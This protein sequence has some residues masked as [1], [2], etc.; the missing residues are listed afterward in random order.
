M[1]RS[2]LIG[3]E[4]RIRILKKNSRCAI[5]TLDPKTA[6]SSREIL[7]NITRNYGGFTGVYATVEET[8]VVNRGDWI[9]SE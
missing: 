4:V 8:G 6:V 5:P 3:K 7:E 1:G 2:L 9:S